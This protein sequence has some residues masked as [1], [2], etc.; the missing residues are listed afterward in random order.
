M[1]IEIVPYSNEYIDGVR[2][3]VLSIQQDEFG[4]QITYEDQLDLH[5][6]S[7]FYRKGIGDFWIA[8]KGTEVVGS[9]GLTD[10]GNN[11]AVLRKMFVKESYRG[12]TH[13]VAK[14]LLDTLLKHARGNGVKEIYLGT[15][16]QFLA[17]HR[18]YEKNGF[19]LI[20]ESDLPENFPRMAV[21][22]RRY[23]LR[24]YEQ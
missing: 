15:T 5:D 19:D 24:L 10:I 1:N 6:I 16:A 7:A 8:L 18:F 21:H 9:I 20:D 23:R 3:L 14:G 11:K 12:A 2:D 17:A 22:T 13:G 4:V